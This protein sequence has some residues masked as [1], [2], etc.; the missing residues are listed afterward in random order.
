MFSRQITALIG[1]IYS[2]DESCDE[3]LEYDDLVTAYK[4]LHARST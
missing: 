4:D 2:D 1:K 3:E